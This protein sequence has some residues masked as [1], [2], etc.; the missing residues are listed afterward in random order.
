[1]ST[2]W[3]D[4]DDDFEGIAIA[5]THSRNGWFCEL[6]SASALRHLASAEHELEH[7]PG[8][9]VAAVGFLDVDDE[10][11]IIVRPGPDGTR[12]LLSD[13]TA[14]VD[15]PIAA[16]ALG[17]LGLQVPDL[18][19]DE[20][21]D[22]E[23]WPEGD[24]SLLADLGLGGPELSVILATHDLY[25]DE[26]L[27]TIAE[28][29]GFA[30]EF[31]AVMEAHDLSVPPQQ[32]LPQ[33]PMPPRPM[34]SE[35]AIDAVRRHIVRR[36]LDTTGYPLSDLVAERFSVGWMVYVPVPE[37]RIAID[38]AI[39]YVADDGAIEHATSATAPSVYI[40]G[41]EERYRQRHPNQP[42]A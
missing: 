28:R 35:S 19:P 24:L 40:A 41:L 22:V 9:G 8:P 18:D 16:E 20:L 27:E 30:R 4:F 36:G 11:L 42:Y 6:M 15:Y 23:P 38:R 39:F 26:Q 5:V 10:F 37:G 33:L 2:N 21:D 29:L 34:L 7:L 12:L 13:A 1:M 32:P 25:A 17:Q 3:A 31:V 14:A